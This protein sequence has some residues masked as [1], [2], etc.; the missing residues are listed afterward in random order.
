MPHGFDWYLIAGAAGVSVFIGCT[1]YYAFKAF[2][3]RR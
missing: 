2:R 1:I 3:G